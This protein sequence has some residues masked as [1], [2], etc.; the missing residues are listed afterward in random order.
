M[1]ERPKPYPDYKSLFVFT[2]RV[3]G[4]DVL[5][6]LVGGAV[7]AAAGASSTVSLVLIEGIN[8]VAVLVVVGNLVRW[9]RADVSRRRLLDEA[10]R[11]GKP[12]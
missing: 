7:L 10:K 3:V 11:S 2:Y 9:A 5:L 1:S 4:V 12:S 6:C 8:A